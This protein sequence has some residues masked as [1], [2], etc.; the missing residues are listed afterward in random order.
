MGPLWSPGSLLHVFI[1]ELDLNLIGL[2]F[3]VP[4]KN[5]RKE[6]VTNETEFDRASHG[7]RRVQLS[8]LCETILPRLRDS[9]AIITGDFNI[10]F[11]YAIKSLEK[12]YGSDLLNRMRQDGWRSAFENGVS[13]DA[14]REPI[15]HTFLSPASRLTI[16]RATYVYELGE[17]KLAGAG[18]I[19]DHSA[20]QL[21]VARAS[22]CD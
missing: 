10:A 18:G 15:D 1:P 21:I 14:R 9:S 16:H 7:D 8:W 17:L 13:P 11:K 6:A 12:K 19:S 2:R 5:G 4:T 22:V 3:L 20:M